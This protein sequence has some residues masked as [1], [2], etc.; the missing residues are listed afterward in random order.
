LFALPNRFYDTAHPCF[1]IPSRRTQGRKADRMSAETQRDPERST[2]GRWRSAGP[3]WW[4]VVALLMLGIL[5]LLLYLWLREP[6]R[7]LRDLPGPGPSA[8][9][10]ALLDERSAENES[11]AAR[12]EALRQDEEALTCPAGTIPDPRAPA[13]LAPRAALPAVDQSLPQGRAPPQLPAD[14]GQTPA[15]QPLVESAAAGDGGPPLSTAELLTR[16]RAATAL[17]LTQYGSGT[18]FF[19]APELL[20]TNRHVVESAEAGQVL[21]TS[22]TLGRISPGQVIATSPPGGQGSADYALVRVPGVTPK[23]VLPLSGAYDSLT[24][25]VAAG[26]PGLTMLNDAGFAQLLAGDATAAPELV[27]N[28]GEVQ[29][30]QRSFRGLE[31]IVHSGDLLQGNSGGPLVDACGRVLG[32]NT[33]IAVD[34]QQ[35]GRV[36]YALSARELAQFLAAHGAPSNLDDSACGPS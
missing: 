3:L 14:A 10:Q 6:E 17:V 36:S 8:E 9:A 11:L 23:A 18:G 29:A 5:G 27:V 16:L 32:I 13:S 12:L 25:V 4:A 1:T 33:Y 24:P 21:V 2:P 34:Q 7:I 28:R 15:R 22:K 19:I 30:V 31:V 35:S 20:V 26:Y